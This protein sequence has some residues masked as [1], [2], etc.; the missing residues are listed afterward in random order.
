LFG[1]TW[2]LRLDRLGLDGFCSELGQEGGIDRA[3][4]KLGQAQVAIEANTRQQG[5]LRCGIERL[6]QRH[7]SG[8]SCFTR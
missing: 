2:D 5:F 6:R 1:G 7:Y 3:A 8:V 4:I